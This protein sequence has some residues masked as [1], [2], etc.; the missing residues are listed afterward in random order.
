M[1]EKRFLHFRSQWPWALNFWPQICSQA[2]L[3]SNLSPMNM[4]FLRF[5]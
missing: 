3:V 4:K 5:S 2:I 1:H